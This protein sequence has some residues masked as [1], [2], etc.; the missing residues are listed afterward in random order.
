MLGYTIFEASAGTPIDYAGEK[1]LRIV[2]ER[3]EATDRYMYDP[4]RDIYYCGK[5]H[6]NASKLKPQ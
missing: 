6:N 2:D 5:K 1:E 3:T 4:Y